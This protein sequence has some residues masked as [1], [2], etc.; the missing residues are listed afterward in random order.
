MIIYGA[1]MAG[2]LAAQ[3]L[4]R[5]SPVVH[6]AQ[7]ELPRN[8]DALLRFR[9]RAV[10]DATGIPFREVRVDKAVYFRGD[11]VTTPTL[12]LGNLYS[13]KVTGE[14]V[15]RSVLD[16]SPG[17]RWVAPPDF[18][19]RLAE[20]VR[21][22]YGSK[23]T[24]EDFAARALTRGE[25]RPAVSTV[26]LPVAVAL[27]AGK[28]RFGAPPLP[29]PAC[30]YLPIWTLTCDVK[31]V[32]VDVFQTIYYPGQE[33]YYRA[34]LTG[35][36]LTVEFASDPTEGEE[37]P[38]LGRVVHEILALHFGLGTRGSATGPFTFKRQAF[39]KILPAPDDR[40]RREAIVR[41]TSDYGVYSLGRFATWRQILLDDVV[42][43]V[44]VVESLVER[45]DS[46][47][48]SIRSL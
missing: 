14:V 23:L 41:L 8:H 7:P 19:D 48:R 5:R 42:N 3:M 24:A 29:E 27:A 34:S 45:G 47:A 44:K 28:L 6:E 33:P 37:K 21:V 22:E 13:L 4:R 31:G 12:Y 35:A 39:G 20:G 38:A 43:D 15:R 10:S 36:R 2:L 1:G 46:Y 11:Y 16:L 18:V 26:P 25:D 17:V 32:G 30:R 9:S 40:L